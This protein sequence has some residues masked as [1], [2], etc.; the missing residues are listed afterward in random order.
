MNP[1]IESARHALKCF[2]II[3]FI[4][5]SFPCSP[6]HAAQ[7]SAANEIIRVWPGAAPGT[8][9]WTGPEEDK[10]GQVAAGKIR[11]ISNVTVPTMTV[12]RPPK[13]K[14]N[15][16]AMLVLPGGAF[17]ALAWDLEGTEIARW[18]ADRGITTFILKYRVRGLQMPPGKSLPTDIHELAKVL[19]PHRQIAIA[20]ATQ[21]VRVLRKRSAELG[22]D[23]DRIGMMGF[24]AGAVTT[25]G[26]L[27]ESPP[28]ARPNFAASIYGMSLTPGDPPAPTDVP[29]IFIAQAQDDELLPPEGSIS[30]FDKWQKA[31]RPAELHIYASGHHGFG[32]RQKDLPVASWPDAFDA[33]L[34][35]LGLLAPK[36]A[37]LPR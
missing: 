21:A 16:T 7:P 14:A 31:K 4:A 3:A 13:G 9:S 36:T 23:R 37:S 30:I 22:I 35:W 15:G 32:M 28:D 25:L 2:V 17:M 5:V 18:L 1:M 24:S 29:P 20:D 8:E 33:W 12:V 10:P 6:L 26:V 27:F 34:K 11:V 19:E